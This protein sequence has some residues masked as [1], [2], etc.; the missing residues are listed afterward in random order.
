MREM[1]LLSHWKSAGVAHPELKK[2]IP[3]DL[4]VTEE[5][6]SFLEQRD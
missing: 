4:E 5:A 6:E 3:V 1:F 2:P